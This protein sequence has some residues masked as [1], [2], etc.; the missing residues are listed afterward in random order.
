M[1]QLYSPRSW[2]L[3]K[4]VIA[5]P[6]FVVGIAIL[7]VLFNFIQGVKAQSYPEYSPIR[8]QFPDSYAGPSF[9]D[10]FNYY[11]DDDPTDGFVTYHH[12][13][14]SNQHT[15]TSTNPSLIAT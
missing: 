12:P 14:P 10:Q 11:S 5:S 9:F 3:R 15:P 7:A 8:Y 13:L 2:S 6:E 4:R 1:K